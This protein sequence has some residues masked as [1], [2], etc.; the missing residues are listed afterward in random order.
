MPVSDHLPAHPF[1]G[2]RSDVK[3]ACPDCPSPLAAGLAIA[4]SAF[5]RWCLGTGLVTTEDL[6]RWQ[7]DANERIAGRR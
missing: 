6:D 7:H 2:G 5:C 4:P 1:G 3:H